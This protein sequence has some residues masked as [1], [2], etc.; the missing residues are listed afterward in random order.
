MPAHHAAGGSAFTSRE[1]LVKAGLAISCPKFGRA[2][3]S[4]FFTA[5][6]RFVSADCKMAWIIRT[7]PRPARPPRLGFTVLQ[8]AIGE[9]NQLRRNLVTLLERPP[10]GRAADD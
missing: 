6:G 5:T 2:P 1:T 7:S 8:N 9:I 10:G 3:M 4:V